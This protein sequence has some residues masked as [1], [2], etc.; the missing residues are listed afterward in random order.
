MGTRASQLQ[1]PAGPRLTR[2]RGDTHRG[3]EE[4]EEEAENKKES[5]RRRRGGGHVGDEGDAGEGGRGHTIEVG[6]GA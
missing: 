5:R 4:E 2:R 6:G 3:E 1:T